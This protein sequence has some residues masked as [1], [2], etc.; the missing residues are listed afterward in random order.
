[1]YLPSLVVPF[2]LFRR[3]YSLKTDEELT[4]LDS[5]SDSLVEDARAALADELQQRKVT[6][7]SPT[8]DGNEAASAARF[9]SGS[10][11]IART[12]W[13]GLW[14]LNTLISTI[15]V[16]ITGGLAIESIR[17]FTTS[18][19]RDHLLWGP[20]HP[21]PVVAGL[22]T[23]YFSYTRFK[24]SYRY[25]TWVAPA[26]LVLAALVEWKGVNQ[27]SWTA[28]GSHFFGNV[29]YPESRDQQDTA[30]WLYMS[31]CYSLGAL[32]QSK[33]RRTAIGSG[34]HAE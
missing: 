16:G 11:F 26:A 21:L 12:K 18:A 3:V 14:L 2:N 30:I 6:A 22:V 28:A 13:A 9:G 31:A 17:S 32:L 15:G 20:Y 33:L 4:A 7:K 24:G 34:L 8:S 1:M 25:W 10:Q 27:S 23:G 5:D 29:P 19:T